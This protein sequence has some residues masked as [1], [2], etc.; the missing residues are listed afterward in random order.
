MLSDAL[1]Q[2]LEALNRAPLSVDAVGAFATAKAPRKQS[3][4]LRHVSEAAP[5]RPGI[6]PSIPGL[7]RRGDVVSNE[8]GAHLQITVALDQLWPGG[9]ALVARRH[10]VLSQRA[11]LPQQPTGKNLAPEL[12]LDGFVKAFPENA[13]L[14]D[15][16]TC[17]FAGSAL[18]L[19]GLLRAVDGRLA[20]ELL[21]ARDYGEEAAVLASLWKRLGSAPLVVTFNGKSF[22]WPMVVDRSRRH[23]LHRGRTLASPQHLDLLHPARRRWRGQVPDCRL[24]TLEDRICGRRR[25][26]DM[27]GSQIPAAYAQFV[28]TGHQREMDAILM[29]N[30]LDLVTL[31]DLAMRL[32]G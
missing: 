29:H 6:V 25:Q 5:L 13:V 22:D 31:L 28:R 30:A 14:L 8:A 23:L 21:L 16:E 1:R 18:F 26:G 17:G 27:P 24:K 4:E 7:T 15:L 12:E 10:A 11:S 20:V 3:V 2:R 9:E 19:V 32:A